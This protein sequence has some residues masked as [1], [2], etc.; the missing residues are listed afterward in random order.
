MSNIYRR[1]VFFIL[2]GVVVNY[3]FSENSVKSQLTGTIYN[4]DSSKI[5]QAAVIWVDNIPWGEVNNWGKYSIMLLPNR[6][7]K[8]TVSRI[9]YKTVNDMVFISTKFIK[10]NYY[11][12][13]DVIQFPEILVE[14]NNA[15]IFNNLGHTQYSIID[16]KRSRTPI[17]LD[18]IR[19]LEGDPS[20]TV[21]SDMNSRISVR[22]GTS[23]QVKYIIDYLPLFEVY[24]IGG[25]LS[26]IN[27]DPLYS[28]D[29]THSG[30]QGDMTEGLSGLIKINTL[31]ESEDSFTGK[32]SLGLLSQSYFVQSQPFAGQYLHLA[33]RRTHYNTA[34]R[35]IKNTFPYGFSDFTG[36]W[37]WRITENFKL[38]L[39]GFKSTDFVTYSGSDSLGNNHQIK[40][41]NNALGI[42]MKIFPNTNIV[43]TSNIYF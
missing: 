11:L 20:I 4:A 35:I 30:F 9:G 19:A 17:L 26:A 21:E 40:W 39:L 43:I 41:G 38:S 1:I 2:S 33:Y 15:T 29:L 3:I 42:E 7:Y 18:P 37:N 23:D 25:I 5:V 16:I 31:S 27:P 32:I 36:K 24:H 28:I 34:G 14:K 13:A 8:I 6:E 22:G 12:T 10:K